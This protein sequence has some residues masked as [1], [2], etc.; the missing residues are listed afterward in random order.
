MNGLIGINYDS[1]RPT[2]SG[3]ELHRALRVETRYNDWFSR[4]CDFGFEEDK[5]FYSNLSKSSGG[6]P[7]EDHELTIPMAKEICMLQRTE[8]GREFRKYFISIEEQWNSPEAVMSRALKYAHD[9]LTA[10]SK[11]N[12]ELLST[13][14]VQN[15]QIAEMQ[16]KASYY[17]IVL[18]CKN[19]L[20]ISVI[21]KDYGLS[22]RHLNQ[23]LHELGVEYKQGDIW[24]LYIGYA[25]KGYTCTKTHSYEGNDG[26]LY[27]RVHTYWTQKGRLF[28]Y[29]LLK[30][31]GV[32][33]LMEREA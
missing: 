17:D 11:Q 7:S 18:Q 33:P 25:N 29:D 20:P 13:V 14:A 15:Q 16:P 9:Q 1:E 10:I 22:G 8:I 5:D 2:V 32:L 26:N 3:R 4:M 6:R 27:S 24:L 23:L 21:A 31:A 28:I 30:K 19:A 12:S